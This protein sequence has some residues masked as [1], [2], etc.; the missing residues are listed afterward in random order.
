MKSKKGI[1]ILSSVVAVC[2]AGLILS[3]FFDWPVDF[4]NAGGNIGKSSRFSRKTATESISN[5]E[6][7]ILNDPSYKNGIVT[8]Y[9]LMQTR[10][11]QF[12]VLVD[13]SNEVAGDI[14]E[15]EGVIDEM[16]KVY[17]TVNNVCASL[18]RA[19][20]NINATLNGEKRP[21]L[22][23]NTINASLAYTTLQKQNKL[24]NQFIEVTDNY[25][26][27]AEADDQL[28]FVRDLWVDYQA[29]TAALEG[30]KE[31]AAELEKKG[32]LL[33]AEKTVATL[34]SFEEVQQL[35]VMNTTCVYNNMGIETNLVKSI[36]GEVMSNYSS[37]L[38]AATQE[39]LQFFFDSFES[40]DLDNN[41]DIATVSSQITGDQDIL[42]IF[43]FDSFESKD[44]DN[45]IDIATVS[46]QITGN[47]AASMLTLTGGAD[48][49]KSMGWETVGNAANG[50]LASSGATGERVKL[51]TRISPFFDSF[52]SKDLDNN[53]DIATG[54]RVN[55][56]FS[57]AFF[58]TVAE[59]T[60]TSVVKSFED[61]SASIK[62]SETG[63][64]LGASANTFSNLGALIEATSI[65]SRP[66]IER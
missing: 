3:H 59:T 48:F 45:N 58:N 33:A 27:K 7:L 63:N 23:Q 6:E 24:A 39:I 62:A 11:Q 32:S 64:I 4:D 20:E 53:I 56:N 22:A 31:F 41:I 30:D 16:N 12:S 42:Q 52:E 43:I 18:L 54:E 19:G 26:K 1:V 36:P 51:N 17:V 25:V 34:G 13:M 57:P 60:F 38:N 29:L 35:V 2:A 61:A 5:M 9:T 40:K 65:G 55:L 47:L 14:P 46:S 50:A 44:L 37:L 49:V 10:A 21:D 66:I 15:F 28:L 8:A